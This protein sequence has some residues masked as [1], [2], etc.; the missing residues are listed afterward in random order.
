MNTP[1]ARELHTVMGPVVVTDDDLPLSATPG[2]SRTALFFIGVVAVITLAAIAIWFAYTEML[3]PAPIAS[4]ELVTRPPLATSSAMPPL[5]APELPTLRYP[6]PEVPA[7][8]PLPALAESDD[9]FVAALA[10]LLGRGDL[11]RWLVP[12]DLIRRIVVTVDNLP[13]KNVPQRMSPLKPVEGAFTVELAGGSPVVAAANARRYESLLQ[14]LDASDAAQ[15][16]AVYVQWYPRFQEAYREL[17][18]P[19]GHFNDRL[20]EAID[21]LLATPATV[22]P[23]T[24][25]QPKVLW[26]YADPRLEALPA[27][28]K[29]LLRI[30]PENADRVKARLAAIRRLVATD[31]TR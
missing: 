22:G 19:N 27:G 21:T 28:Q 24:V 16:V 7:G 15:L 13:R 4:P 31:Q 12:Q 3:A 25:V 2:R 29:I 9:S 17:G 11:G 18:Y 23:L 10:A 20:V 6:L 30:G 5:A 26:E 1:A 8:A 14:M